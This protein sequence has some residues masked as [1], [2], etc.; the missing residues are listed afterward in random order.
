MGS[1]PLYL[2]CF[3]GAAGNMILGALLDAGVPSRVVREGLGKL[4]I[5]GI[6]MRVQRVRRGAL[7][8]RYVGFRG[9]ERDSRER[10]YREIRKLL[11]RASLPAGVRERSER[12]FEALAI[13]EGRVHGIPVED[14]HFHEVGAI[15][16]IGD[17][18]GTALALEHLGVES[19]TA[20]P[21]PLGRGTVQSEHG[22]LPLPAPAT[23]ELL[24][25]VP[26]Y[27]ADTD[28]ETVTPTGAAIVATLAEE[29]GPLPAIIPDRV[30]YG[31]GDDRATELPNVLRVVVGEP[32][33]RLET[34]T[35][36]VLETNLD[37]MSP[38]QLPFLLERLLEEGAL[39]VTVTPLLMKKGRPGQLLSVLARPS[40][41][42]RLAR[43]ILADSTAIGVR[44]YD[45]PR[46]KLPRESRT[47]ETQYG[48]VRVKVVSG[49]NGQVVAAPEYE[50]ARRAALRHDVAIAEV[51]REAERAAR[52][53]RT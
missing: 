4:G 11:A 51:Y 6:R 33:R 14:V 39:D 32:E 50:S 49:P 47:V 29:F 42:D 7:A 30:G 22:T 3:S 10:R 2:D 17:I 8:A 18:V 19:I 9:P 44:T 36:C 52:G 28:E 53:D 24:R 23:L 20:S 25:G 34:D 40:E 43:R 21:L 27:P 41:R 5:E 13:A 26:T 31:A 35:V 37:D 15:D 16:A 46:L 48:R 45:T 1:R 12:V 38:E